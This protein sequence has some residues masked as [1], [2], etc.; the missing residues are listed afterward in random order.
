MQQTQ[1]S[2]IYE[3]FSFLFSLISNRR[4]TLC[5]FKN[6]FQLKKVAVTIDGY[7]DIPP[8]DEQRLLKA[9][10]KQPVSVG[11]CGSDN[12]IQFYSKVGLTIQ[13]Y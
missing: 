13:I 6:T 4:L 10:A 12:A 1:G 7:T 11:I 3:F 9:V 8:K 5:P 2:Y